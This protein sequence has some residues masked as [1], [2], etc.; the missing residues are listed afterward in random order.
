[1][2]RKTTDVF[3]WKFI[4]IKENEGKRSI[5]G[6]RKSALPMPGEPSYIDIGLNKSYIFRRDRT[7]AES[8]G[9][10]LHGP[11]RSTYPG[12]DC[13]LLSLTLES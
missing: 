10:A 8:F 1:M 11:T 13:T 4:R 6:E 3:E 9:E 7:V 2:T 12:Q 5:C